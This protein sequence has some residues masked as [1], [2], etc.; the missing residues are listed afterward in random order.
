M[1]FV[2][3]LFGKG[4]VSLNP[5]VSP[6]VVESSNSWINPGNGLSPNGTYT[7]YNSNGGTT[8]YSAG[9]FPATIVPTGSA[10]KGIELY[11]T[12]YSSTANVWTTGQIYLGKTPGTR[13]G[14]NKGD[15]GSGGN[16]WST[17]PETKIFGG[18]TDLWGE[19]WTVAEVR[20]LSIFT[21]PSNYPFVSA[22]FYLDGYAVRVYT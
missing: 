20:A 2:H 14:N 18:P 6:T 10:I 5:I 3:P 7:T 12:G 9:S 15:N 4:G 21:A 13:T 17:T 8:N 22:T 1:F 16:F 11:V 19:T